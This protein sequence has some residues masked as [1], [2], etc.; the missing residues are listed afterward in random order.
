[1][2]ETQKNNLRPRTADNDKGPKIWR[3]RPRAADEDK[4]PKIWKPRPRAEDEDEEGDEE[5]QAGGV[6]K[7]ELKKNT[8]WI[9]INV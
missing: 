6:R 4:G 3:P 9:I 1:M 5:A 2:S 8:V 7:N